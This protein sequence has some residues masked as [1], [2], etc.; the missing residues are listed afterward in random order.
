MIQYSRVTELP[1]GEPVSL[2][3]AKTHLEISDD[4]KDTYILMQIKRA[5]RMC[6]GYAGL[7]FITQER[8]VKMDYFPCNTPQNRYAEI[9]V[10]YGPVQDVSVTY[11]D[12]NGDEQTLVQGTDFKL[13]SGDLARIV[14]LNESG[15]IGSWPS[16]KNVPDCITITYT[17]GYDD[18]SG[19]RIPEEAKLAI[20]LQVGTLFEN[21]Q[22]EVVGTTGN[23]SVQLNLNSKAILDNIKVYWNANY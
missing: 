22:D 19:E 17:A 20:L 6:E 4:S 7:S 16:T 15:D 23:A 5:R 14:P 8:E 12:S 2:E 11:T 13:L 3:E 10:P 1:D 21:R 9:I 18:V